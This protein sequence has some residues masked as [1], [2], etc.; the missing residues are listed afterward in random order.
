MFKNA[1]AINYS[2]CTAVVLLFLLSACNNS[3]TLF[4]HV[5][6]AASGIQ[7]ANNITETDSLNPLDNALMYN[8][9][10]VATGDFNSDGLPDIYFTGNQV[11][12][13]LY[14]NKGQLNFQD[15][16]AASGTD[17]NGAWCSGV[18]VVDI[19][20]DGLPD[21]YVCTSMKL[22]GS[23]QG[24][25]LYVNL[26]ADAKG[27]PHFKEQA[28]EYG[29]ADAG[30]YNVQAAFFDFDNDGDLDMYLL[31]TMPPGGNTRA[32]RPLISDGSSP[33]TDKLFRNDWNDSL[34]HP[35]YTDVSKAAGIR[36][37]GFG[38]GLAVAD[39]N[40]D[41]W[42]DIY[43]SNDFNSVDECYI[44]NHDG[45]FTNKVHEYF[46]HTSF[47][48][49]G[50][51]IAD[52][53]NDG[54]PD[55]VTL[56]MNAE[57]NYRKKMNMDGSNYNNYLFM[58]H[59]NYEL[60]YVRNTLQ[61]NQGRRIDTANKPGE[62]IFA[63]IGFYAGIAATDWSWSVLAADFDNDGFKDLAITNGYPRDVTDHDYAAFLY[64]QKSQGYHLTKTQ[65]AEPIP[66]IKL[67]NYIFRNTGNLRYENAGRQWGINTPS[68]SNGALY[69]D[70]DN[71]GDLDYVVNN[72]N[73][74]AFLYENTTNTSSKNNYLRIKCKGG[75][76]NKDGIGAIV[77]LFCDSGK[78]QLFENAP[79]RGYLSS[80][81]PFA[82]FGLGNT[83]M[84]DSVVVEW[85]N[86]LHETI[87][88]IKAKQTIVADFANA[89]TR[90]LQQP[91]IQPLFSNITAA[92]GL[93]HADK[94][95]DFNDFNIQ[96][97]LPH[98]F[99]E[100]GPALCAADINNDGLDD[101]YVGGSYNE[102]GCFWVQKPN[103]TFIKKVLP[104]YD[105]PQEEMGALLFDADG[106][107]NID[108]YVSSGGV[109]NFQYGLGYQDKLFIN[110]GKGNFSPAK[111]ALPPNTAS[112][113]CVKAADFDH[114]GD[115][116]LFIGCRY[117]PGSYPKAVSG[118]IL[119]NDSRPGNVKFT[120]VTQQVAPALMNIGMIC[121]AIFTD[122]DNDGWLDLLIAGEWMAP[123]ILKNNKGK[124]ENITPAT[125]LQHETGWWN[126]I[127]AG[128]FDNDG[129]I[130]YILGN[131]GEN[132]FHVPSPQYPVSL[133]SVDID[134]NGSA[135]PI[136]TQ[137]IVNKINSNG[138]Y[139]KMEEFPSQLRDDIT[140]QVPVLKK[141][142][143]AYKDYALATISEI[144]TPEKSKT[145]LVLK[146][147]NAKSSLLQN[148]GN[149][150][151]SI[152]PLPP[153]AQFAPAFSMVTD[154]VDGD[155]NL[156]IV[157]NGN[158]YG[159]EASLGPA[160]ALNGLL[161]QGDGKCNFKATSIGKSG[162]FIPGNGKSLIKLKGAGNKYLLAAGTHSGP[163]QLFGLKKSL[164]NIPLSSTDNWVVYEY[165]NGTKRKEEFYYG[166]SFLSQSARFIAVNSGVK[167][168]TMANNAGRERTV[169][170]DKNKY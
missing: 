78:I 13:A 43:V 56:D 133:Y 152:I 143:L 162:I 134:G 35:V 82:H 75:L 163:V 90:Q 125:G 49:M 42:K 93:I 112:K 159:N 73:D 105:F 77:K 21:I 25:L 70:L 16:T 62:P 136:M 2:S 5:A 129:D 147:T 139:G 161:L 137:Y 145:A 109:R 115:L 165:A 123:T 138:S 146:A 142:Y 68:F 3:I 84:V 67:P 27:I 101:I 124:F 157:L 141:R 118:I 14:I 106:D 79:C 31:R 108:L 127:A 153:E 41:G 150:T 36:F 52:L 110:D 57:D 164:Q 9:G 12:N 38:L 86:G 61:L 85:Y 107:G 99:S 126:S 7:F 53:N 160:D 47:N 98:K 130:D 113:S 140:D 154:D 29:L 156:D 88:N 54:L 104:P 30:G 37:E 71:D 72:V 168:I 58:Q 87:K 166:S 46:K 55:V 6:A 89:K 65:L 66:Q 144:L 96:R 24:N 83:T 117:V 100:Y 17:G 59:F 51:E 116:D 131:Q 40:Q 94:S 81:E 103:G 102:A 170:F 155:G 120:E 33:N 34:K 26:G 169:M 20:Q 60:Q 28:A 151:F 111:N 119:R 132:A 149:N 97:L 1:T 135:E 158:E 148:L 114:D 76:H 64:Q 48:A 69:A 74:K 23:Q 8:G 44:N 95:E 39:I 4:R 167:K 63:E 128:D 22:N 11:K 15:V 10:G 91:V 122:T 92:S 18:A 32:F 50:T 45:S 121:D 19:N 80:A